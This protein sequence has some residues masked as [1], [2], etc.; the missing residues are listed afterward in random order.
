VVMAVY[1]TAF[2]LTLNRQKMDGDHGRTFTARYKVTQSADLPGKIGYA[3][4]TQSSFLPLVKWDRRLL[5]GSVQRWP[6]ASREYPW[7]WAWPALLVGAVWLAWRYPAS[8][9]AA[10]ERRGSTQPLGAPSPSPQ[11]PGD[12]PPPAYATKGRADEGDEL[13]APDLRGLFAFGALMWLYALVPLVASQEKWPALRLGYV[14]GLGQHLVVAAGLWWLW[15]LAGQAWPAA[16]PPAGRA[17]LAG[18]LCLF[19]LGNVVEGRSYWVAHRLNLEHADQLRA[20]IGN[21]P[22]G[23]RIAVFVGNVPWYSRNWSVRHCD[24]IVN[25]W[26]Y[27]WAVSP[28]LRHTFGRDIVYYSVGGHQHVEPQHVADDWDRLYAFTFDH[29][30]DPREVSSGETPDD[31][32]IPVGSILFSDPRKNRGY[33]IDLPRMRREPPPNQPA[34]VREPF[35]MGVPDIDRVRFATWEPRGE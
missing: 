22:P 16:G 28:Y 33:R 7:M 24:H 6:E 11:P 19:T 30:S 13:V 35:R 5:I 29:R 31:R 20:W 14:P 23:K 4:D 12:A 17:A 15:R 25:V 21:P 3:L 26:I 9:R 1:M 27:P 34:A 10:E 8:R 18:L 32:L 2:F